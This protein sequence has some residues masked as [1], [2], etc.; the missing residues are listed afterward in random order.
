VLLTNITSDQISSTPGN[1]PGRNESAAPPGNAR[2]KASADIEAPAPVNN[3]RRDV[4][5]SISSDPYSF[6]CGGDGMR[7]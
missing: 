1:R 2:R 3:L 6:R 4:S 7:N 5:I